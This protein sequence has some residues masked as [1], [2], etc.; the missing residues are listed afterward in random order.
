MTDLNGQLLELLDRSG[1]KLHALLTKL[2]LRQDIAEELMQELF[3]KLSTASDKISNLNAY[4]YRAAIN[5]AFD[6]R[7]KNKQIPVPIEEIYEPAANDCPVLDRL[8]QNE[9]IQ[10]VLCAIGQL[11]NAAREAFVMRY[12]QEESYEYI[13]E[14]LG[15]EPHQVRALCS[16]AM[17]N[18]RDILGRNHSPYNTKETTYD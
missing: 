4:A 13:S 1:A 9:Q 11:N 18:L 5:L 3:I 12:I 6:Y 8:V 2:T 17:G 16:K 7:R 15:K 10:E 14:Q